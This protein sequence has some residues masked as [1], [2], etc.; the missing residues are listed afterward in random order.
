MQSARDDTLYNQMSCEMQIPFNITIPVYNRYI[1]LRYLHCEGF[2]D[3]RGMPRQV[4][5]VYFF[6]GF[7]PKFS[8]NK[9]SPLLENTKTVADS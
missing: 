6:Q 8:V 4:S 9:R 3:A 2:E 7:K 5:I 1:V